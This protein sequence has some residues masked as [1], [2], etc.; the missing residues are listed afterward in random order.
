VLVRETIRTA[1]RSLASNGLRTALTALGMVIG[2]A[3]VVSVLAIGEGARQQ[4]EGRIRSLGSNLLTIRPGSGE[5]GGI[6]SGQVETLTMSDATAL[7]RLSGVRRVSPEANGNAQVKWREQNMSSQI[8]G[9]T[10]VFLEVRSIGV[11][12]GIGFG[13]EEVA[14]R[15]RVA[16][17]GANVADELF[18][19][20][21]AVGER[22]QIRGVAFTVLGVLERKGDAGFASPDDLV[23]VPISTHQG[24]LF[25]GESLSNV[26]IQVEREGVSAGVQASAE[27]LLR[28][29]HGIRPGADDDFNVR[30]QTEILATM[31]EITGT[32]TALLGSVAAVS[33]LVG[34]IG[35]MNIML[36]SVRE[37]T[38]EIGIRMAVGARRRDVLLQFLVEA[39]VVSL[40]GGLLGLVLGYGGAFAIARLGGWETIV[41]PYAVVLALGVSVL[42]GLVFGVGPARRAAKLDPVEALRQE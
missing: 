13:E 15:A 41:P 26:T 24:S 18:Q 11:A 10:P 30:S 39:I 9:V 38:R 7:A 20:R 40:F 29:R 8:L 5:R 1:W 6:R 28:L 31:G 14:Q 33:L 32:F 16:L 3:A 42:I 35:I 34:G 37:R 36:V 22:I 21:P 23:L 19:G 25:G 2:V 27:E 17:V 4:V 12:S